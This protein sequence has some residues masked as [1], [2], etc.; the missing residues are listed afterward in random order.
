M[1]HSIGE[2]RQQAVDAIQIQL[3]QAGAVE[4]DRRQVL[5]HLRALESVKGARRTVRDG[6]TE[7]QR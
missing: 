4:E 3:Q 6:E 5:T 2:R 7:R 1:V